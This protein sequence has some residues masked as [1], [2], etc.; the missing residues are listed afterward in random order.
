MQKKY[1]LVSVS[2]KTGLEPLARRLARL[3]YVFLS[4]GGT[5]KALK[6]IEGLEVI[7]VSDYTGFPEMLDGRL[8]TLHPL[9]H[10]GLLARRDSPKHTEEIAERGIKDIDLVCVNLYP[11]ETEIAKPGA[12]ADDVLEQTDIG[13]PAMLRSAAKGKRLVVCDPADYPRVIAAIEERKVDE[14][15][16]NELRVKVFMHTARYDLASARYHSGGRIDGFIGEKP[17]H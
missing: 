17:T 11:L 4:T 16:L 3:G 7:E 1:A 2:D 8:K 14:A 10:G 13:G 12:T 5:A 9:V 15:F 6:S